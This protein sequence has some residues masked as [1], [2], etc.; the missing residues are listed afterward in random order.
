MFFQGEYYLMEERKTSIINAIQT[1]VWLVLKQS[2]VLLDQD[3]MS[4]DHEMR[5]IRKSRAIFPEV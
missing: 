5:K 4:I 1:M 3:L 2:E